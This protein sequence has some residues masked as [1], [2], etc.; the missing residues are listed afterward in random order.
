MLLAGAVPQVAIKEGTSKPLSCVLQSLCCP[1]P[2][3]AP[4]PET[5]S[6]PGGPRC[7]W[8]PAFSQTQV[9]HEAQIQLC[10]SGCAQSFCPF[11]TG[12][13]SCLCQ[14][15]RHIIQREI[16]EPVYRHLS[17]KFTEWTYGPIHVSL[18]DLSSLDSFEENSVLEILAYSSDTPVRLSPSSDTGVCCPFLQCCCIISTFRVNVAFQVI[19][20]LKKKVTIRGNACGFCYSEAAWL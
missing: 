10:C 14:I 8:L 16:K 7:S 19:I 18:Y 9:F 11:S 1:C 12:T 4:C 15:F 2:V 13:L 20:A 6:T 17:R 3:P 5:A